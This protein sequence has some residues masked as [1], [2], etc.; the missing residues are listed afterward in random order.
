MTGLPPK[1]GDVLPPRLTRCLERETENGTE[2]GTGKEKGKGKGTGTGKGKG[3]GKGKEKGK[4]KGKGKEKGKGKGKEIE[5]EIETVGDVVHLTHAAFPLPDTTPGD[6][7]GET[8]IDIKISLLELHETGMKEKV[9]GSEL[10]TYVPD[11]RPSDPRLAAARRRLS[12]ASRHKLSRSPSRTRSPSSRRYHRSESNP[13]SKSPSPRGYSG[14]RRSPPRRPASPQ[15]S[16]NAPSHERRSPRS[17]RSHS[18]QHRSE[19][20][21]SKRQEVEP[22]P[23]PSTDFLN[24]AKSSSISVVHSPN[25]KSVPSVAGLAT[26]PPPLG[27][28]RQ[29]TPTGPRVR[30]PIH[31]AQDKLTE[32]TAI[33]DTKGKGKEIHRD[34]SD[35]RQHRERSRSPLRESRKP[36]RRSPLRESR[37][38]TRRSRSP[39][40]PLSHS[41]SPSHSQPHSL[42]DT[43][44]ENAAHLKKELVDKGGRKLHNIDDLIMP[45]APPRESKTLEQDTELKRIKEQR[46]KLDLEHVSVTRAVRRAQHE[47]DLA[48]LELKYAEERRKA[49]EKAHER[50]VRGYLPPIA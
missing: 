13:G 24:K 20:S 19:I 46:A 42:H 35:H 23:P 3:K 39:S 38:P 36:T 1:P 22:K 14:R 9:E 45:Q 25:E 17:D 31:K 49:A 28:K 21:S 10:D 32:T 48:L 34:D 7:Q 29:R 4:G 11:T 12:P 8:M 43:P 26:H 27:P 16:W 30:S 50:T 2:K 6:G 33:R 15:R 41:H 47:L 44:L 40:M 18:P 37:K 5:I